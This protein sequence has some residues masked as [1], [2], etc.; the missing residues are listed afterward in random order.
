M[1]VFFQVDT[2]NECCIVAQDC[3]R[4]SQECAGFM[5]LEITNGGAW[6]KSNL[7]HVFHGF[8][9]SERGRE[10]SRDRINR[11]AGKILS[12]GRGLCVEKIT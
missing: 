7:R 10:I 4:A 11:Q 6:K 3:P 12:Q 5:R 9:Q 8:R 2:N 1:F